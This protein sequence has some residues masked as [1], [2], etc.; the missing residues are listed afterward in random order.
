MRALTRVHLSN[1]WEI[2]TESAK[3]PQWHPK[4]IIS[5]HR[6]L[7]GMQP[8]RGLQQGTRRCG[9]LSGH[10]LANLTGELDQSLRRFARTEASLISTCLVAVSSVRLR[11]LARERRCC[12]AWAR[13]D[14]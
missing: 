4:P 5:S 2:L 12:S 7:E 10:G 8:R 1:R 11:C 6:R 3:D 14:S 13:S 9:S